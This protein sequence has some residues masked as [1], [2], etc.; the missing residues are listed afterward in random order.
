MVRKT[1]CS[2]Y[3]DRPEMC[4][5]YPQTDGRYVPP[6]CG[7]FFPGDGTRRG[8]CDPECEA[9]CC[10]LTRQDGEP[11]GLPLEDYLGGLPCKYLA[12]IEGEDDEKAKEG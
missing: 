7:F 3:K 9:A 11:L 5:N 8:E 6:S 2:I 1:I 4:R 12:W 10:R